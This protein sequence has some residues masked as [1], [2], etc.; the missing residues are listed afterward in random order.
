MPE[1]FFFVPDEKKISTAA[2]VCWVL[3]TGMNSRLKFKKHRQNAV[4]RWLNNL[5]DR[6]P[7]AD[8]VAVGIYA[9]NPE[10]EDFSLEA[11][12]LQHKEPDEGNSSTFN[13]ISSS[14]PV[15]RGSKQHMAIRDAMSG[16]RACDSKPSK[17]GTAIRRVTFNLTEGECNANTEEEAECVD[18][19]EN[20]GTS[21]ED[22]K[23]NMVEF[24]KVVANR[25]GRGE[26]KSISRAEAYVIK[27]D[28]VGY[29]LINQGTL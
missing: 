21:H 19:K 14:T 6:N 4:E 12:N 22:L 29:D 11:L 13:N 7:D 3:C 17:D 9:D 24:L 15:V 18:R 23:R 1:C 2:T 20:T 10:L 26:R 8:D 25:K 5:Q 28:S 27:N 16:Q